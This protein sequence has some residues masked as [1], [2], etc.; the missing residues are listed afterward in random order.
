MKDS[1]SFSLAVMTGGCAFV[2]GGGAVTASAGG[3]ETSGDARATTVAIGCGFDFSFF[4]F[5]AF[6]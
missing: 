2:A 4:A 1:L 3:L 5:G 6:C